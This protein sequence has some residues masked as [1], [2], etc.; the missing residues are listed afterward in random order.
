VLPVNLFFVTNSFPLELLFLFLPSTMSLSAIMR[1]G[2]PVA[3]AQLELEKQLG[4]DQRRGFPILRVQR[5]YPLTGQV[6]SPKLGLG[7]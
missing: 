2:G 1:G 7:F 3:G 4:L 6:W 5:R